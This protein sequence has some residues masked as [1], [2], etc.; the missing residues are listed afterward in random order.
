MHTVKLDMSFHVDHI[1]E[2]LWGPWPWTMVTMALQRS[3]QGK[4]AQPLGRWAVPSLIAVALDSS[5]LSPWSV[6]WG[7]CCPGDIDAPWFVPLLREE[8]A[9]STSNRH[10]P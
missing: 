9:V 7:R 4:E 10:L 6:A 8:D 5:L 3:Q 1:P 2:M